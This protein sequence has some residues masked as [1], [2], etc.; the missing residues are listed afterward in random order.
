MS[1]KERERKK[2]IT[3]RDALFRDPGDGIFSNSKREFVLQDPSLNL[4]AGVREDAIDYF[5]RNDISWWRGSDEDEPTGHLLSSQIACVNHLFPLRQRKALADCVINN[6]D[7]TIKS[8]SFIDTGYVEF[9]KTGATPLGKEK[10]IQRGA[11]STSIDALMIGER[12]NGERV[13]I[14]IE[15]KYTESYTN[16]PIMISESG[17]NRLDNYKDLLEDND[18]PI[19]CDN[20][21]DLFY[22][23]YYQLMRQTLLGWEMVRRK[24]Y[25]ANDWIHIHVIPKQNEEL[26]NTITSKNLKGKSLEESWKLL[27]KDPNKYYVL[28]PEE[29]L[30]P[31]EN[32][33]D[34]KSILSYLKKRYWD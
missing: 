21:E 16:K 9:E 13:L 6:I 33:E 26:R 15:W 1:Y 24:E 5:K 3:I 18:S 34:T 7:L 19:Q 4:W 14:L 10:S 28:S 29:F 11:N 22:E 23:P 27:L 12:L 30:K 31:I 25:D 2:V 17:K 8:S 20:F 32:I